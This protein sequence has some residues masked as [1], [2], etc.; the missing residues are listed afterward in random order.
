MKPARSTTNDPVKSRRIYHHLDRDCSRRLQA[1]Q[2]FSDKRSIGGEG[3]GVDIWHCG[4]DRYWRSGLG[5]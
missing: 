3:V 1:K 5:L 2:F 4:P